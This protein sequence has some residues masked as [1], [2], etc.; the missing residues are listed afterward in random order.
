MCSVDQ[1]RQAL[2]VIRAL[3][4]L[5]YAAVD[6]S[7][8]GKNDVFLQDRFRYHFKEYD[9][10]TR[11]E[12]SEPRLENSSIARHMGSVWSGSVVLGQDRFT[13]FI[14]LFT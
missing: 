11:F 1:W 9:T 12:V 3:A 7:R 2:T 13:R 6:A 10:Q 5:T 14:E 4:G 8:E